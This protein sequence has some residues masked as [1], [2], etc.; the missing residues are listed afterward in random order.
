MRNIL[1]ITLLLLLLTFVASESVAQQTMIRNSRIFRGVE[2]MSYSV[3]FKWGLI[4]GKVG[5]ATIINRSLANHQHFSQLLFK[6]WGI[7]ES[8]Y[9]MRDTLETLYSAEHLPLRFEKR[10]TDEGYRLCD[11]MTL[12]YEGNG[13]KLD[14]LTKTPTAVMMD[15]TFYLDNRTI[16][17]IDLLS[18]MALIRSFDVKNLK[19]GDKHK[20]VIPIS[21]DIVYGEMEVARFTPVK[22]PD[23]KEVSGI[24][25][26]MHIKDKSFTTNK[27]SIEIY[28][29]RDE[30]LCP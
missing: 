30:N 4:R 3:N 11:E 12:S 27:N 17:V 7:G 21:R 15:S 19:V 20:F 25:L 24:K 14:L 18:S 8:V 26:Y 1:Q 6:T 10:I 9:K 16:E 5:E 13:V 2:T 23:G 22:V 29:T 28:L